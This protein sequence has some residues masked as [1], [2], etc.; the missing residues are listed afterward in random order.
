MTQMTIPRALVTTI[1]VLFL[2]AFTAGPAAADTE[3]HGAEGDRATPAGSN[4][5]VPRPAKR[6]CLNPALARIIGGK[7]MDMV[8]GM[9]V[10]SKGNAYFSGESKSFG[11]SFYGDI[12]VAKL[13][14]Q[15]KLA[16][17]INYGGKEDDGIHAPDEN[18][19][20]NGPASMIAIDDK[21]NVYVVGRGKSHGKIYAGIALKLSPAGKLLWSRF[22]RPKWD[23]RSSSAAEFHAVAVHDNVVH[24]VGVTSGETQSLVM[25][26]DATS[27]NL[28]A[29]MAMDPSPGSNDR[30]YSLAVEKSGKAVYVGG[31]AGTG[32]QGMLMKLDFSGKAYSMAWARKVP[33]P[34]GSNFPSLALDGAGGLYAVADIHGAKT[35]SELHKYGTEKGKL[36]WVRRYNAGTANGRTQTHVV[37]VFGEHLFLA[38]KI[39]LTGTHTHADSFGDGFFV[40]LDR[41]GKLKRE[42]YFF[43]GTNPKSFDAVKDV[44]LHGKDLYVVGWH[45]GAASVGE[46]RDA[47]DYK[48]IKHGW[49]EVDR[50]EYR[51]P[52]VEVK[53]DSLASADPLRDGKT[54]KEYTF[55]DEAG[56]SAYVE[57]PKKGLKKPASNSV[58][59][60]LFK[61]YL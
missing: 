57:A 48:T 19:E 24:I 18:I 4:I 20:G 14:P 28:L 9:V 25:A 35:H 30:L 43:T 52:N 8:A 3:C 54:I 59:F 46:W 32:P 22:Y 41:D 13:T 38:G 21:D 27:G 47:N 40:L 45:H 23:N 39:G 2:V 53:T 49:T 44:E 34:R 31:W 61:N 1:A 58:Y 15:G 37:K 26:L 42:H 51:A 11:D 12:F 50:R 10:D 55:D 36:Q 6:S 16:W 5:G 17:L 33:L 29:R 7:A 56:D 60:F